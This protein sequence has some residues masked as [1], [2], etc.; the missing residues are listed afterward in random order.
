MLSVNEILVLSSQDSEQLRLLVTALANEL[1]G[2]GVEVAIL[3]RAPSLRRTLQ[4]QWKNLR[5]HGLLWIPYRIFVFILELIRQLIGEGHKVLTLPFPESA[6]V[7]RVPSFTSQKFLKEVRAGAYQIGVVFGAPI[8]RKE[9]FSIPKFGMVNVHQGI[10]PYFRGMPP[11][12]WELFYNSSETGVSVHRVT[13]ALD[14]GD[15]FLQERVAIQP[16][17]TVESLQQRLNEITIGALPR[18]VKEIIEGAAHSFPVDLTLGTVYRRP[19]A[20]QIIQLAL[21]G[22]CRIS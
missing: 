17:D 16:S 7:R 9:L 12:F 21:R 2:Y 14:G 15:V 11:A 3:T 5:Y 1:P 20:A 8:L 6:R 10:T 22:K 13:E 18:V 19:K 4:R